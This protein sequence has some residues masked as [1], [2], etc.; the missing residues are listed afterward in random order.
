MTCNNV[1]WEE[2]VICAPENFRKRLSISDPMSLFMQLLNCIILFSYWNILFGHREIFPK[3][4]RICLLF[5]QSLTLS[6]FTRRNLPFYFP[7]L[8]ISGRHKSKVL[9]LQERSLWHRRRRLAVILLC[10]FYYLIN[11]NTT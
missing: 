10:S 5:S 4:V 1:C 9:F 11:M 7:A 8:Q 3:T 2:C 6:K